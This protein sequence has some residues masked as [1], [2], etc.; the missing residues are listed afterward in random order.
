VRWLR[1]LGSIPDT[2]HAA[3]DL[4]VEGVE[5]AAALEQVRMSDEYRQERQ[6]G[7]VS[8]AGTTASF[9]GADC[10]PETSSAA[11]D[12]FTAQANL[13]NSP[14][15][16]DA[17]AEAYETATGPFATRLVAALNAAQRAGRRRPR[18]DVGCAACRR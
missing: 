11:G 12:G 13:M 16:C 14:R 18:S 6:V 5:P 17:M 3:S 2:D 15:V 10:L 9:T 8:A 1:R 4:L 7:L